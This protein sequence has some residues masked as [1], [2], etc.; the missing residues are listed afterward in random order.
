MN[1]V[2]RTDEPHDRL[3]RLCA[4]MTDALDADPERGDEKCI[5]FITDGK[6][7]GIV[8]HGYEDDTEPM[9]DLLLHLRAIFK[10]NG[11]ELTIVP[12]QPGWG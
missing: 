5:V 2:R 9:V 4:V 8:L 10:A 12:I 6:L 1:D 7:N 11:K 3:T